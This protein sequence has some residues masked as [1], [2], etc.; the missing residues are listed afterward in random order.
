MVQLIGFVKAV[1]T[2]EPYKPGGN[3]KVQLGSEDAGL[4]VH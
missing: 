2:G 1:L 4:S 3:E